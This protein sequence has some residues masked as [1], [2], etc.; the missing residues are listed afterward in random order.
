MLLQLDGKI[1]HQQKSNIENGN[2]D[3]NITKNLLSKNIYLLKIFNNSQT[4]FSKLLKP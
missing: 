4:Y 2:Y 1:I 3:I